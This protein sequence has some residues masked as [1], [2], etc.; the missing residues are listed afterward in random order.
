[1]ILYPAIDLK[2]GQAVR[3]VHGDMQQ[4]TVFNDDPA[5]QAQEFVDAPSR[6]RTPIWCAK[7]R[8][9][10]PAKSP[11]ALTRETVVWQPKAGQ[12]RPM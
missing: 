6:S 12:R 7:P 3:L 8:A 1:M 4:S 2:D 5:A 11:S 9:P 10:F